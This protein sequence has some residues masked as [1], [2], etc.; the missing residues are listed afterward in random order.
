VQPNAP[1]VWTRTRCKLSGRS[2]T[3]NNGQQGKPTELQLPIE[4]VDERGAEVKANK[5]FFPT[6]QVI[7]IKLEIH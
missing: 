5:M 3:A 1:E 4:E 7:E 6:F 2:S